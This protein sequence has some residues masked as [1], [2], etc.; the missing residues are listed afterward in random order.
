[1]YTVLY[2]THHICCSKLRRGKTLVMTVDTDACAGTR[3]QVNYIEHVQAFI[4][5]KATR[6]GS[7]V[8]HLKSPMNTT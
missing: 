1:M 3:N 5:L 4:S 6:R 8:M 7:V 2:G